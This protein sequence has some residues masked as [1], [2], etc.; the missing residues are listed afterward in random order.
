MSTKSEL[1]EKLTTLNRIAETLNQAVD[2]R[3]VLNNALADLVNLMG[4]ETGWIFLRDPGAPAQRLGSGYVLA[5]HHNLPPALDLEKANVWDRSCICQRQCNED[6]LVQAYNEVHCQRIHEA[7][8]DRRGLAMHASTPL[9]SGDRILGILN[10]AAP[11]WSSFSPE[12]LALLTTV[13]NQIG[14]ALERAR[15][16]D[17]VQ[18]QRVHEQAVL[19]DL[20]N[21]LLSRRDLEDL[22]GYLVE[23]VR[24]LMDADACALLLPSDD[25]R[26]LEFRAVS[27]WQVDPVA[28]QQGVSADGPTG[29]ALA[30]RSQQPFVAKD[31]IAHPSSAVLPDWLRAEGFR[32]HAVAP[33]VCEGRSV[34]ALVID[35]R[36]PSLPS[37]DD[38]RLLRLLGNQAAIAIENARLHERELQAEGLERELALGREIQLRLLPKQ[39]PEVPGW[40]FATFYRA[41]REV[42]GDFY[43]LFEVPGPAGQHSNRSGG[44]LGLV[45]A[46]VTGKG[47]PAALFMAL[48]RTVLRSTTLNGSDLP[49]ALRQANKLILHD[50]EADL[51]LTAFYGRLDPRGHMVYVN[52]GHNP[53]LWLRATTGRV[54]SLPGQG[55][56]LGAL[57]EI[58]LEQREIEV[59]PGDYLV[60]FTDG[61]TEALG[62]GRQR[63]EEERLR[64][65]VAASAGGSA[66]QMLDAIVDA[67]RAFCGDVSQS[68]DMTLCVVRRLP[69]SS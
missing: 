18:E 29:P 43:D 47:V 14:T 68:D 16:Y 41:A 39:A 24:R 54:E 34:G 26:M 36:R 23:E 20:S 50:N 21:Q 67:V 40:E 13:G 51:F 2:V 57:D 46:D 45:I 10:V 31:I 63:F 42:G 8:G 19:L 65:A 62:S 7:P 44:Q 28:Q 61:V 27:G 12:A 58:F 37:Q 33:L 48:S 69:D 25:G 60:L 11:D 59:A 3:G 53:P 22:I 5:A 38:L 4:L 30:M 35:N 55:T 52:A 1:I 66:Q 32:G 56:V 17:M 15:L 9:R 49:A 6:C 64:A